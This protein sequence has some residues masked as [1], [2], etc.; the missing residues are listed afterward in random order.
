LD[1]GDGLFVLDVVFAI[2]A[3]E[4]VEPSGSV[5]KGLCLKDEAKDESDRAQDYVHPVDP[6]EA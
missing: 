4:I 3:F 1:G 5:V 2:F 6:D